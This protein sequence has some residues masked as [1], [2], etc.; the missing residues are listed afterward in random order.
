MTR[1]EITDWFSYHKPSDK[2][3]HVM[4]GWRH[5]L[6]EVAKDFADNTPP[7][8][9]V[10]V[11]LRALKAAMMAMNAALVSPMPKRTPPNG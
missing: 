7:S 6:I 1:E 2:E 3:V 10:I 8:G 4:Q 5:A 9:D 11:A